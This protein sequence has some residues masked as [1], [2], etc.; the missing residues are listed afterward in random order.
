MTV[1][2]PSDGNQVTTV[3]DNKFL[4]WDLGQ[5][6]AQLVTVGI[7]EGKGIIYHMPL[8]NAFH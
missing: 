4:L 5:A 6:D 8:L 3:V 1:F 7:L 2:N